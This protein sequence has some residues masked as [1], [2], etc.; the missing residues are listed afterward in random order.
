MYPLFYIS[1]RGQCEGSIGGN[2]IISSKMGILSMNSSTFCVSNTYSKL[3]FVPKPVKLWRET[4]SAFVLILSLFPEPCFSNPCINNGDCNSPIT[5]SSYT[6][7]C[8]NSYQGPNCQYPSKYWSPSSRLDRGPRSNPHCLS[9][10]FH[11]RHCPQG[12][13]PC[14]Q[15]HTVLWSASAKHAHT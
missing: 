14:T 6:C 9:C 11:K 13:S 10:L 5:G 1:D 12:F 2:I 15:Y 3:I 8:L 4:F 7:T